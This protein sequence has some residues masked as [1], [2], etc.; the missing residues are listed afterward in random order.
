MEG[1]SGWN[2]CIMRGKKFKIL[3]L[4]VISHDASRWKSHAKTNGD[5]CSH[6]SVRLVPE[7]FAPVRIGIRP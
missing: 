2:R 4:Y 3:Q 5:V 6:H 7:K 1:G